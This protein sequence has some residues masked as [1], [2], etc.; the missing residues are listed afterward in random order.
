MLIAMA[1]LPGTG[2]ST[3]AARLAEPLAA[4]V[5][6]KD[7]VRAALF[8]PPVLDYCRAQDDLCMDAI[9][10]AAAYTLKTF[11]LQPVI[12]D[13]RTFLRAYQVRDLLALAES[14]GERPRLIECTCTDE[15]ARARLEKDLAEGRHP[16]RNR[17]YA[18]YRELKA[19]SE[20]LL[21]PRLVLD[22]GELSL[23]ECVQRSLAYLRDSQ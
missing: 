1:G 23:E 15:L 18:L 20:P 17:T 19:T 4:V 14:V 10:R 22:T 21:V 6:S 13:A 16:A 12:L 3:L 5:L 7:T 11:P 8:P 2:K 9:F